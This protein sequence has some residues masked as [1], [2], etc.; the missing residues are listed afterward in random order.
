MDTKYSNGNKVFN[1]L[2]DMFDYMEKEGYE[3][4]KQLS[5]YDIHHNFTFNNW[6]YVKESN[7]CGCFSCG[8]IFDASE[9]EESY[10]KEGSGIITALCPYCGIDSVV[11]DS[12]VEL[13]PKLILQMNREWFGG[14]KEKE[15]IKMYGLNDVD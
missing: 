8:K 6:E 9:L 12:K 10:I 11:P 2:D 15:I 5:T 1:S 4:M 14:D 7:K 3:E 13:T